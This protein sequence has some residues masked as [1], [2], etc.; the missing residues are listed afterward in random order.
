MVMTIKDRIL[1][2]SFSHVTTLV[3]TEV[4][5]IKM[6]NNNEK[7]I[8]NTYNSIL[9]FFAIKPMKG[10]CHFISAAM[11]ILLK[12]QNIHCELMIGDV[13]DDSFPT[14]FSHS[15]VEIDKQIYDI[16]IMFPHFMEGQ[17]PIFADI[18]L[19]NNEKTT[20]KYGIDGKLRV[21]DKVAQNAIKLSVSEYLDGQPLLWK[22][23]FK[24]GKRIL[25]GKTLD[26][27]RETYK[28]KKRV[29]K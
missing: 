17:P 26:E 14:C 25:K 20:R 2:K 11:Y 22:D 21:N 6:Q 27:L 13:K 5:G 16:A 1:T 23:I 9:D 4:N 28:D 7:E 15:W 12:E 24:M 29:V 19:G 3:K 8:K 10:G 18:D